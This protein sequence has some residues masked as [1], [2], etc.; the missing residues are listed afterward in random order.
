M[1]TNYVEKLLVVEGYDDQHVVK[2]LVEM[3]NPELEF[4]IKCVEGYP[5]LLDSIYGEV[6]VSGRKR[7]GF[8]LDADDN[9]DGHW[10]DVKK[11]LVHAGVSP[12]DNL[13]KSG[14]IFGTDPIVGVWIMP[15]NDSKGELENFYIKMI[16]S[17]DS[18]WPLAAQFID[19]IP[20]GAQK[21]DIT[22]LEKAEKAKLFAWLATRKKPGRM[23]PP[24]SKGE[25]DVTSDLSVKFLK[26]LD[27]LFG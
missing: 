9:L 11:K 17:E 26:W 2:H 13:G 5:N 27:K 23:G 4:G 15:N 14:C 1:E 12:P 6:Q 19:E 20:T 18:I 10:E 22:N 25:V 16:P 7:I 8:L 21:F 3:N 24:I